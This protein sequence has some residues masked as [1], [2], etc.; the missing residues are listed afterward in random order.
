MAN[1]TASTTTTPLDD[2][3]LGIVT[4]LTHKLTLN[5]G[6][7]PPS[8][9]SFWRV[10]G[11][12]MSLSVPAD[13]AVAMA[14]AV[15]EHL[16][17]TWDEDFDV[18]GRPSLEAYEVLTSKISD[19]E[20]G[21]EDEDDDDDA[22]GELAAE[23]QILVSPIDLPVNTLIEWVDNKTLILDPDWQRGYVWKTPR[24]RR[25]IESMFM[26]LPIPPVLLF[27]DKDSKH[28]VIDGRQRLETIYR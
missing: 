25:F 1:N 3:V 26:A 5:G 12:T 6:V 9:E 11:S 16:G 15:L 14:K 10:I 19:R 4:E 8:A 24:K 21:E 7:V 23:T 2:E 22:T 27:Q 13:S 20:R 17:V 18:D 28:Y